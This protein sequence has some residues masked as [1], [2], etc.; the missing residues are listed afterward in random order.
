M[1]G[2][3]GSIFGPTGVVGGI[4]VA[5]LICVAIKIY[6]HFHSR[7]TGL[8]KSYKDSHLLLD[9]TKTVE[10]I[11]RESLPGRK[12]KGRTKQYEK[13][14]GYPQALEDFEKLG[15]SDVENIPDGKR[16]ILSDGR[17]VN[18]RTKSSA[19]KPTLEVYDKKTQ[20]RIKIRYK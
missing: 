16:G 6:T 5:G 17:E 7:T 15:P 13:E 8:G 19:T 4:A 20:R 18:V 11:L 3:I 2:G 10:D 14:G 1:R 12:I 9:A